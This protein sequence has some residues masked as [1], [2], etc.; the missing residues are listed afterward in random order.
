MKKK[1]KKNFVQ[2]FP[3]KKNFRQNSK[4]IQKKFAQFFREKNLVIKFNFS[5]K[6]KFDS[7]LKFFPKD[8]Q[9]I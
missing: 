3:K 2:F 1:I 7:K 5:K 4:K 6:L 9:N 8:K